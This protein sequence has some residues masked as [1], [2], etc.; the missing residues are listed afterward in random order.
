MRT[1]AAAAGGSA[2]EGRGCGGGCGGGGGGGGG[3]GD[4]RTST[5][6]SFSVASSSS[7]FFTAALL[8]NG[9][10]FLFLP[11]PFSL[12]LS[13]LYLD[14]E[15]VDEG[16]QQGGDLA[17]GP[18]KGRTCGW[19]TDCN[20]CSRDDRQC[21]QLSVRRGRNLPNYPA[22]ICQIYGSI[23]FSYALLHICR[24]L[25]KKLRPKIFAFQTD[26]KHMPDLTVLV[27]PCMPIGNAG[28]K[29]SDI[30]AVVA[31]SDPA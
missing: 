30:N 26:A 3:G 29:R 1:S 5:T 11:R 24:F 7:F 19:V 25:K 12:S 21:C 20:F 9:H 6:S 15:S 31:Q 23:F 28:K 14:C 10:H 17:I 22:K 4:D 18:M 16:K 27:I 8:M 13:S 2:I